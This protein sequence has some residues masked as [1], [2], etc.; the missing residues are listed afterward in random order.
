[1]KPCVSVP[2]SLNCNYVTVNPE[3]CIVT[4]RYDKIVIADEMVHLGNELVP[5]G[6]GTSVAVC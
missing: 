2:E 1:M 6:A 4:V 5:I 3:A